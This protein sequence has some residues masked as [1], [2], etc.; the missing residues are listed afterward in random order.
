MSCSSKLAY[1]VKVVQVLSS[2]I[3]FENFHCSFSVLMFD[4]SKFAA[5][6]LKPFG[7]FLG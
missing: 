4:L 5:V 3:L 7:P 1:Q 6:R 2:A